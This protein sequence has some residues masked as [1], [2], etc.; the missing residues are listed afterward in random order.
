MACKRGGCGSCVEILFNFGILKMA[1]LSIRKLLYKRHEWLCW[2]DISCGR[3]GRS[4][5][6]DQSYFPYYS[7]YQVK[8]VLA[9]PRFLCS[10]LM[11][12]SPIKA[13]PVTNFHHEPPFPACLTPFAEHD[14]SWALAQQA[15]WLA[16]GAQSQPHMRGRFMDILLKCLSKWYV[17]VVD[18]WVFCLRAD[19]QDGVLRHPWREALR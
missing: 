19:Q 16:S 8:Q 14:R 2:W 12:N 13:S 6:V 5:K 17:F 7:F 1:P 3:L 9:T 10:T 15:R 11:W 4:C 18:W